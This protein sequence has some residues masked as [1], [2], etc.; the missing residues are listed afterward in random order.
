MESDKR[1]IIV[2]SIESGVGSFLTFYIVS[3][4]LVNFI[5]YFILFLFVIIAAIRT[6]TAIVHWYRRVQLLKYFSFP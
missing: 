6:D 3:R 1:I 4:R 5:I 2:R